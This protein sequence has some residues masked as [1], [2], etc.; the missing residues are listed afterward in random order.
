MSGLGVCGGL[1]IITHNL[2]VYLTFK[3][4]APFYHK[5]FSQSFFR[6]VSKL[7]PHN[8]TFHIIKYMK[9]AKNELIVLEASHHPLVHIDGTHLL[10]SSPGILFQVDVSAEYLF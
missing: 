7:C 8:I 9:K 6:S 4:K 1:V 3:Y 2:F 10:T 5:S